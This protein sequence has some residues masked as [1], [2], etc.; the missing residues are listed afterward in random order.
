VTVAL[1]IAA[2]CLLSLLGLLSVSLNSNQNALQQTGASRVAAAIMADLRT[3]QTM[4]PITVTSPLFGIALPPTGTVTRTF[5]LTEDGSPAGLPGANAD[6]SLNPWYRATIV[7]T[8]PATG[9]QKFATM[10]R[11]FLTWPALADGV[12]AAAPA[13]YSGSFEVMA[14]LDRN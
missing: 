2:F 1:G 6:P 9:T 13:N 14:A 12:A 8:A 3:T 5:F 11:L 4:T 7:L 10:A